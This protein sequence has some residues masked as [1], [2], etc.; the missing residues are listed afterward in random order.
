ML[1]WLLLGAAGVVVAACG[2]APFVPA[3]PYYTPSVY[4]I[5]NRVNALAGVGLVMVVY[6]AIGVVGTLVRATSGSA[7]AG[8][9]VTV[10][11]AC[12][13]GATYLHVI[14]RH[15]EIWERAFEAQMAGLAQMKTLNPDLPDGSV[16]FV[17]G[18]PAYQTLGVPIFSTAWDVN[19]A[20][21][22]QYRNG[23]LAAYPVISGTRLVCTAAGVR[24]VGFAT[25]EVEVAYG[26]ARLFDVPS[27][28]RA[29]PRSRAE[30]ERTA[31][32]FV[33]G[34][35]YLDLSY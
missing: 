27:G 4:G 30:C 7:R 28:R 31:P 34:P 33:P 5:T 26:Q 22:V 13:L 1:R 35:F 10:V 3:D 25:G 14:D 29:A 20:I 18:Y 21:K 23:R 2:W 16:L 8:R 6:A 9:V 15:S 11:L 19:G 32:T 12:G 17:S 24:L